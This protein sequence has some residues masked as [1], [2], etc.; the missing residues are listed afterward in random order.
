MIDVK[1]K[2]RVVIEFLL[3]EGCEDDNIVLRLQN[4][5]SRDAYCRS[6]VFRWMNEIR[7][8]NEEL[9]NEGRPGRPFRY[10]RM[11]FFVQFCAMI[12]M[13]HCEP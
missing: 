2:Q 6:S 4:A 9:R 12:R 3:L 11:L 8:G 7:H 10:E 13:P 5:Y 1:H